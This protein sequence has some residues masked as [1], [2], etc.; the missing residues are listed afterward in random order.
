MKRPFVPS[1][2]D[3]AFAVFGEEDDD[4]V[5]AAA[6]APFSL[7]GEE[8]EDKE[9]R[10]EPH[11]FL[12]RRGDAKEVCFEILASKSPEVLYN[13]C[14]DLMR[15]PLGSHH[16]LYLNNFQLEQASALPLFH[17]MLTLTLPWSSSSSPNDVWSAFC[18]PRI[19]LPPTFE[20]PLCLKFPPHHAWGLLLWAPAGLCFCA[21][22]AAAAAAPTVLLEI[23]SMVPYEADTQRFGPMAFVWMQAPPATA[24]LTLSF[25]SIQPDGDLCSFFALTTATETPMEC[26]EAQFTPWQTMIERSRVLRAPADP[27]PEERQRKKKSEARALAVS[28]TVHAMEPA[29]FSLL[30]GAS[31]FRVL[32]RSALLGAAASDK[33]P[34]SMVL[35]PTR[36][37]RYPY[38]FDIVFASAQDQWRLEPLYRYVSK[39]KRWARWVMAGSRPLRI[40]ELDLSM[41]AADLQTLANALPVRYFQLPEYLD[42]GRHAAPIFND[43]ERLLG[44]YV[45]VCKWNVWPLRSDN[46]DDD[47]D[48]ANGTARLPPDGGVGISHAIQLAQHLLTLGNQLFGTPVEF[49]TLVQPL[50]FLLRRSQRALELARSQTLT[51]T[52]TTTIRQSLSDTTTTLVSP[53]SPKSNH[54]H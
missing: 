9:T 49:F 28:N 35:H 47:E 6:T 11:L 31:G 29:A 3:W 15:H 7:G 34:P 23:Y 32:E 21:S 45:E 41:R 22:A 20:N 36:S 2:R 10:I 30:G 19:S 46:D 26:E 18:L 52:T 40:L 17:A 51:P 13:L 24:T 33:Q 27:T 16:C 5:A 38:H 1:P 8:A 48:A 39:D 37:L 43:Y 42:N 14:L 4:D 53:S 54:V 44:E 25:W 12:V 50:T